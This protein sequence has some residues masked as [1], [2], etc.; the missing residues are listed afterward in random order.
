MSRP[1]ASSC[2]GG[3]EELTPGGGDPL[4]ALPVV[5]I[6]AATLARPATWRHFAGGS[7]GAYSLTPTAWQA[8]V[9]ADAARARDPGAQSH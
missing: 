9:A 3:R 5:L 4:A 6:A 7:V 8:L 2:R 1:A